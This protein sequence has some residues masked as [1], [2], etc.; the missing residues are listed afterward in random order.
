VAEKQLILVGGGARSGKS[1][2]AL[3]LARRLGRR[4]LFVATAEA[5]DD[6]M[7]LRIRRHREERGPD[8]DT[9]EEPLELARALREVK[10]HDV[11]LIDCLTLW[12]ANRLLAAPEP[13]VVLTHVDELLAAL[14]KQHAHV[15]VVTNEVGLGIVPESELGRQ[16][17]DLAGMA[18]Q[19]LS[20][21]AD[22]V[23]FAVLG[24]MLRLKPSLAYIDPAEVEA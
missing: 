12:L 23:Y 13:G 20:R 3:A 6:E 21:Q 14:S 1:S 15:I 9:V 22:E 17:R 4:R 7:H 18:H 16:F 2:F 10:E 5:R 11:V 19:R 8:F 24:T